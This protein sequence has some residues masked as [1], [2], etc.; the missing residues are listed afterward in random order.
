M[1]RTS[2]LLCA[3][4]LLGCGTATLIS[5]D[6][7]SLTEP[8]VDSSEAASPLS[9][10]TRPLLS[11]NLGIVPR[12]AWGARTPGHCRA[13]QTPNRVVVHHV[14]GDVSDSLNWLQNYQR[15]LR[16]N[17]G[18]CDLMYHFG[19]DEDGRIYEMVATGIRGAHATD[20]NLN[21]VG[22]VLM[23]DYTA[24]LPSDAQ[25]AALQ[26]LLVALHQVYGIALNRDAIVGHRQVGQTACPG[27]TAYPHL[28]EW[29]AGA[30][31]PV[32]PSGAQ[33]VSFSLPTFVATSS[34]LRL[35]SV[36]SR[37][38]LD[39]RATSA[40]TGSATAF[41]AND[42]GGAQAVSLGVTL[43]NPEA[44]TFLSVSPG[45]DVA[46]TSTVNALANTVRANQTLVSLSAG[47][48]SMR[49]PQRTDVVLDE[50]ARFGAVGKGF[51]ALG[52]MRAVDTRE[53]SPLAAGEVRVIDLTALGVPTTAV[54]AQVNLAAIPRGAPGF[55]SLLSCGEAP[56]TSAVN[57]DAQHVASGAALAPLS[58]GRL[59]AF[60]NTEVDLVIDVAGSFDDGGTALTLAAPVR[61]L[62]TRDGQ[63]GFVGVPRADQVLT[64]D[65]RAMPHF[66]GSAAVAV[67]VTGVNATAD[68]FTQVWDCTGT[69][70]HSNQNATPGAVVATFSV[71]RSSGLLCLRTT[72]PQH[73]VVDLVGVYR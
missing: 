57:F 45:T 51:F 19:V 23:G 25:I 59:C 62:D 55:V 49:S 38:L 68:G 14:G 52:P 16:D 66:P 15:E 2:I 42:V 71:V 8:T 30:Q 58:Q 22:I 47:V 69:P 12:E 34:A 53:T 41:S 28:D 13:A 73:L 24:R 29:V 3:L 7:D 31:Q 67:N 63:G 44:A 46:P 18:W 6:D 64:L 70:T 60:A 36:S 54:A 5:S 56:S 39:T 50:Q 32:P 21:S 10:D 40:L 35:S 33:P 1:F 72:A 11:M 37:R 43:V 20:G 65:L 17:R 61:L 27:N 26:K 9:A 4:T 48:V